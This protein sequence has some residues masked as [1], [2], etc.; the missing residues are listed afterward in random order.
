MIAE[1]S[2]SF[3]SGHTTIAV[4]FYGLIIWYFLLRK[5][6]KKENILPILAGSIGILIIALS[7]LILGVHYYFDVIGG[8]ILG[9]ICLLTSILVFRFV[10][11]FIYKRKK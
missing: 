7:R 10:E 8:K 5:G 3:P 9:T 1:T 4:A 2:Y 11:S 6:F